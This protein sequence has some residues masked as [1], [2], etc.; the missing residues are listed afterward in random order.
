MGC[1]EYPYVLYVGPNMPAP[2]ARSW[3]GFPF[4]HLAQPSSGDGELEGLGTAPTKKKSRLPAESA[5]HSHNVDRQL[6]AS[7]H[8]ITAQPPRWSNDLG[9]AVCGCSRD[10]RVA[11]FHRET[12]R[13][14]EVQIIF[15]ASARPAHLAR[16]WKRPPDTKVTSMAPVPCLEQGIRA[17]HPPQH[18]WTACNHLDY[19]KGGA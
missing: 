11:L 12:R 2:S 5:S 18:G 1:T 4:R 10:P 14:E 6:F 8:H 7:K 15:A 17:H 3:H 16:P 19:L 13:L 9:S